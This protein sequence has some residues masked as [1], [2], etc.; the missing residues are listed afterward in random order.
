MYF[1]LSCETLMLDKEKYSNIS[2][3]GPEILAPSC[4]WI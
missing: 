4:L 1:I 3:M 2:A